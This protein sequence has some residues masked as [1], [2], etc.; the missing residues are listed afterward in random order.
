MFI[1]LI[2]IIDLSGSKLIHSILLLSTLLLIIY[3]TH[4]ISS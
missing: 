2:G 1:K 4:H 3:L